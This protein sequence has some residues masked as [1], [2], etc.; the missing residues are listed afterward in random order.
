MTSNIAIA[1]GA[2]DNIPP[3]ALA[4]SRWFLVFLVFLPFVY[5][6]LIKKKKNLLRKNFLNYFF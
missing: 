1:R 6:T 3:I 4:S 2:L 5:S